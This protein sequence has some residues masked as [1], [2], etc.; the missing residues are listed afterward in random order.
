MK[1]QNCECVCSLIQVNYYTDYLLKQ[2]KT[3]PAIYYWGRK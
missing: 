1:K 3:S 2:K